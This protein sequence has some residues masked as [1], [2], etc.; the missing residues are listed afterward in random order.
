[1]NCRSFAIETSPAPVK[2]TGSDEVTEVSETAKMEDP[3]SRILNKF[4]EVEPFEPILSENRSPVAVVADP[5]DQ[6]RFISEPIPAAPVRAVDFVRTSNNVPDERVLVSVPDAGTVE[7]WA[8]LPVVIESD[9]RNNPVP[10]L[11]AVA[12]ITNADVDVVPV[13]AREVKV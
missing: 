13:V 1:M 9:V 2:L 3:E 7:I 11:T 10:E 4:P 5:G 6:S 8:N 12:S